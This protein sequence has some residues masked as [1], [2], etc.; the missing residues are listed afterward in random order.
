M[1]VPYGIVCDRCRTLHLIPEKGKTSRI[2]YDRQQ[3][4]FRA[5]CIPPCP[6]IIYSHTRMLMS[7]MVTDEAVQCGYVNV[8]DCRPI[9]KIP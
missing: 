6:N 8:D 4:A 1:P 5:Q 7:Y 9:A 3:R 2:H